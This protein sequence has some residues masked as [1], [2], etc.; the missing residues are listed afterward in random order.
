MEKNLYIDASHPNETRIILKS[1]NS[2]EEY[3]F[4]DKNNLT[5][6]NNIYLG[7]ISRVEPSLQAAFVNFG[8]D[9]H[10]FLAFNDIQSD[11]YQI[12]SEDKEKI[13]EAEEE[14]RESLKNKN[15]EDAGERSSSNSTPENVSEENSETLKSGE[16]EK[17]EYREVIK[18][19]YGI[20]RYKIQE[21]IKPG[22]IIL[23]QVIKEERG[24]KGAAL[25]TFISL[26]GKYMVLMPNT[27]KG[28]GISRKIFNSSDRQKIRTI[29]NEIQ[30]PKSMGVIVRTAGANKTKNEIEK[31]F[32]NTLKTWEEI[33]DKA[34]DSNA[35]SLVYEEGDIIKRTL[36][37]TYDNDTKNIY[38]EG[39]EAY[40]KAK[41]FMKELMPRNVKNIKKYRGKKPLFQD[42]NIEKELNNIFEPTVKLKSGGYIV[43]NP[44][45][46][47]VSIDIN[48]GQSTKQINIEKT[49]LNTNLEAA[50]EIARQIKLRDLSGLI[51]ID[52][53]DMMNFYNR[54]TVEKKM[55]ESIR[56]DRARIQIG[57]ISNFGLLEMTR[58]RLREGSIK[59]ETQL[60]LGSFSQKILKKIQHVAFGDKVKI[61]KSYVPE[62]V[63]L[64]IEKNLLEELKYFQKKYAFKVEILSNKELII[65]EYKIEL[66]N[67]SKKLVNKLEH[68]ENII[69]IKKTKIDFSKEKKEAKKSKKEIKKVKTKKNLR[70]LWVRRKK[71][72]N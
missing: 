31:D 28:G 47:L 68:L 60:S 45:E 58:Q 2:I 59:W 22:Q 46:A 36:R 55:R 61:V 34:I 9:R 69:S 5:F 25:T 54:R 56:K 66:L 17:K 1:T 52:F 42:A 8:R 64:Y 49:A 65:P 62:K 4:E 24:Q 38:I 6:K 39:N 3:E 50:E 18:S 37:D 19:S 30:I 14:I 41:K 7:T 15:L 48:S 51:V 21:V 67:K 20:K 27:P 10:G 26:A 43:I 70:T 57:K 11:Y 23:I 63:K 71:K 32:Q 40:Q 72:L 53:I 44:T 12:P 13:K 33:K 29:L 35:P 16:I